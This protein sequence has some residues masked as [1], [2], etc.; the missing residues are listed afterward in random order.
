MKIAGIDLGKRRIAAVTYLLTADD[1]I[2]IKD[3]T[4]VL[5]HPTLRGQE[6]LDLSKAAA[7]LAQSQQWEYA[8][9]EEPLVGRSVK[10]S[11]SLSETAGAILAYLTQI[12]VRTEYVNVKTWK[13]RIIG[14]GNA[15]KT[16]IEEHVKRAYPRY[17]EV[18]DD[19][20]QFDAACIGLFGVHTIREA[21]A[22]AE[23]GRLSGTTA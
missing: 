14:N 8:F 12:G 23:P 20:D 3:A 11:A 9:I 10:A 4:S 1:K 15:S 7:L 21:R 6:L 13:S 5:L 18:C 22:M 19:Q 16:Q 17:A 2:V